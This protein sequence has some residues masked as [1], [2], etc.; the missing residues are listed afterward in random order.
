MVPLL[1]TILELIAA[2]ALGIV[3]ICV[4]VLVHGLTLYPAPLAPIV[5]TG[6]EEM[7]WLTLAMLL[8]IGT[9][10]GALF[11]PRPPFAAVASISGLIVVATAE[12]VVS[13]TSHNLWPIEFF[14]YGLLVATPVFV[15]AYGAR[16]MARRWRP[17]RNPDH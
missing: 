15:A 9:L 4:P 13:P 6:I 5:R 10:E 3:A 16:A 8:L 1:R 2:A 14:L 17:P 12:M 7:S 11:S